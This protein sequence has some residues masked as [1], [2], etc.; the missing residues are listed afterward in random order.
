MQVATRV[1]DLHVRMMILGVGNPGNRIDEGHGAVEV[2]EAE[3]LLDAL[4]RRCQLPAGQQAQ[5]SLDA[6][7]TDPSAKSQV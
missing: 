7:C 2:V 3:L 1:A 4:P 6:S 5:V